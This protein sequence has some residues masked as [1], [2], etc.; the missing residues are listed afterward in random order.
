[1]PKGATLTRFINSVSVNLKWFPKERAFPS[2]CLSA[3]VQK[4]LLPLPRFKIYTI[5]FSVSN[6]SEELSWVSSFG[7]SS[8]KVVG[9]SMR[10]IAA[11]S[12]VA[13]SNVADDCASVP[14]VAAVVVLV[15]VVVE[16]VEEE[17]EEA[18]GV[19]TSSSSS[20]SAPTSKEGRETLTFL[21]PL[22]VFFSTS[23][24]KSSSSSSFDVD[25]GLAGDAAPRNRSGPRVRIKTGRTAWIFA[26]KIYKIGG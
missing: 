25:G 12:K 6:L 23:E 16:E 7:C 5:W 3:V 18:T 19:S 8:S 22:F 11:S 14:E 9:R 2:Y 10:V 15:V 1:M 13:S 17:L 26:S 21:P 20:S 24:A 4:R